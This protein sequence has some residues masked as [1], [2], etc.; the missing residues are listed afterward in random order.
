M[1][2]VPFGWNGMFA[3]NDEIAW[4]CIQK[5]W[6]TLPIIPGAVLRS[7]ED[8]VVKVYSPRMVMAGIYWYRGKRFR[9][10]FPEDETSQTG[11]VKSICAGFFIYNG[12]VAIATCFE[13][14]YYLFRLMH[15][16]GGAGFLQSGLILP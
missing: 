10:G 1:P 3:P 16:E 6:D 2:R 4:L 13:V 14:G 7:V 12:L 5:A 8:S 9:S 15:D 11:T